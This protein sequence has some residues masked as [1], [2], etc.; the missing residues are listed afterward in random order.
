M[1]LVPSPQ[2]P[3]QWYVPYRSTRLWG[4]LV[5]VAYTAQILLAGYTAVIARPSSDS[6][7]PA[8]VQHYSLMLATR[9]ATAALALIVFFVWA[10]R[11]QR[12][13]PA[14]G[15][16]RPRFTPF[17]A[18]AWYFVPL[19]SF[20]RPCQVMHETLAG[21]D[22]GGL[23]VEHGKQVEPNELIIAWWL[24]LLVGAWL[25]WIV[26]GVASTGGG[27][28]EFD[29]YIPPFRWQVVLSAALAVHA[30]L[31]MLVVQ[32]IEERQQQRIARCGARIEAPP[33][34]QRFR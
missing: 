23:R 13:L 33:L 6:S 31:T 26:P 12:N 22:L 9:D 20:F 1:T 17:W 5:Y 4:A 19:F 3:P 27:D 7:I 29:I 18:V 28:F 14:L 32:A 34:A 30:V 24:A 16:P 11:A 25:E 2:Q 15:V 8:V 21:S 10:Y